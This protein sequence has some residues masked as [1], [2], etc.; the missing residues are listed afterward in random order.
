MSLS[1]RILARPGE[2]AEKWVS[3]VSIGSCSHI[4]SSWRGLAL[5][6]EHLPST[7]RC[8]RRI[9]AVIVNAAVAS[10][11][12][13]SRR[14]DQPPLRALVDTDTLHPS[15]DVEAWLDDS[16][17]RLLRQDI[18]APS[19]CALSQEA[20]HARRLRRRSPAL[21]SL[22]GANAPLSTLRQTL[23]GNE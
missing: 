6:V 22:G 1:G 7:R 16:T 23:S 19:T 13:T 17:A 21:P 18:P 4:R 8:V 15:R 5:R 9:Y 20:R 10:F 12:A 3:S 11:T 14:R 2:P